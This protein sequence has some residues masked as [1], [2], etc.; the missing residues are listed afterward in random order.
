[1][2][3]LKIQ[4]GRLRQ[5]VE[6]ILDLSRLELGQTKGVTMAPVNLNE[7]VEQVVIAH[8]PRAE[9][10]DL[11]LV[12][13]PGAD[14]PLIQG[15]RNQLAQMVTNLVTNAI[16]YTPAGHVLIST[17]LI[18]ERDQVCLQVEDTG[19]GIEPEDLP[20]LFERFYRGQ[21][22]SQ[23]DIPGSGLGLGILKEIV[24]LH[25]GEIEVESQVGKGSTF[26]V[27]LPLA[28]DMD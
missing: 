19:M 4:A 5:L 28:K 17:R 20:H 26:R 27:F 7:I 22:V 24:V 6:D 12:F 8:L 18:P 11:K 14:L 1:M 23:S 16:N 2:S 15:E 10:A 9:E 3:V 21:R 13:T 25:K